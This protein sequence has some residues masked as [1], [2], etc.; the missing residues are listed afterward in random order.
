[1]NNVEA[2]LKLW[3][4]DWKL[5]GRSETTMRNRQYC[6][7]PLLE[8]NDQLTLAVVKIWLAEA[9]EPET[10]RFRAVTARAFCKWATAEEMG[11]YVWWDKIPVPTVA[12]KPQQTAT[13]AEAKAVLLRC[14]SVRD[15]AIVAVLW[16]SGVRV[17][18]LCRMR[19]EDL[20]LNEGR[21]IIPKSKMGK[22]RT[23]FLDDRAVKLLIRLVGKRTEGPVFLGQRGRGAGKPLTENGVGQMLRRMGAPEAH[24]WRRGWATEMLRQG[25]GEIDVMR[26][27]GWKSLAMVARYTQVAGEELAIA[28]ARA[29]WVG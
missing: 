28:N 14:G 2:V 27:G 26:L 9:A 1:V 8:A 11:D 24:A 3:A 25:V 6:M 16:S 29:R 23:T 7:R 12:E 15:K 18:E 13:A 4:A 10:R 22:A 17:G 19:I 21:V 20:L 5:Q